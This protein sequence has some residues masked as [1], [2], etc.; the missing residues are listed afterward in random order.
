MIT[1]DKIKEANKKRRHRG[2]LDID[3]NDSDQSTYHGMVLENMDTKEKIRFDTGDFIIDYL[4]YKLYIESSLTSTLRSISHSSGVDHFFMDGDRYKEH[5]IEFNE[6]GEDAR[7]LKSD[8]L[9]SMPMN[10]WNK[11]PSYAFLKTMKTFKELRNY[12]KSWKDN[13]LDYY[14]N[15][16]DKHEMI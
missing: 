7:I 16:R 2:W 13:N 14:E 1:E 3:Y 11:Y 6:T 5:Y 8:E 9:N 15:W 12:W 4:M 10:D